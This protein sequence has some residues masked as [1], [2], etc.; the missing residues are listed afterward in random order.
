MTKQILNKVVFFYHGALNDKA[1][2]V[3]NLAEIRT[4]LRSQAVREGV[5]GCN[6]LSVINLRS[7]LRSLPP[8]GLPVLADFG[9]NRNAAYLAA[10]ARAVFL[11]GSAAPLK[12]SSGKSLGEIEASIYQSAC[13]LWGAPFSIA[14]NERLTILKQVRARRYQRLRGLLQ[15]IATHPELKALLDPVVHAVA[16]T[17]IFTTTAALEIAERPDV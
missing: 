4:L 14:L 16:K 15:R 11:D 5:V 9:T 6:L 12:F 1:T 8:G 13:A 17:E 7:P 10:H 3:G 2:C